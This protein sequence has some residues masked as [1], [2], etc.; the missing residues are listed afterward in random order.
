MRIFAKRSHHSN[1]SGQEFLTE[2]YILSRSDEFIRS[3]VLNAGH[4]TI[5]QTDVDFWPACA[6]RPGGETAWRR[7]DQAA[8]WPG[9]G[10]AAAKW[11]A[12][13]R[14]RRNGVDRRCTLRH[15]DL[16]TKETEFPL[17]E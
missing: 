12:A 3:I 8:E 11:L 7:N 14:R 6:G 9:G 5:R 10:T 13:K 1:G 16:A 4:A 15:S 2:F 17:A